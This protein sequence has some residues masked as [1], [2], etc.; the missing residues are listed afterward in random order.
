MTV[1]EILMSKNPELCR[2]ICELFCVE[3]RV[4]RN[5]EVFVDWAWEMTH[6]SEGRYLNYAARAYRT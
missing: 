1:Y 2:Y 6:D 3:V 4:E 5:V